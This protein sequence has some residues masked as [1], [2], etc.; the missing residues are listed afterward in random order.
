MDEQKKKAFVDHQS[1]LI[2]LIEEKH[3]KKKQERVD[4]LE[5]GR[6][7]RQKLAEE[8]QKLEVIKDQKIKEMEKLGLNDNVKKQL[9]HVK[10]QI[11]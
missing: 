8:Q 5:E 10:Y 1:A 4:F 6:K 11:I 9:Q 2:Q 7:M 3:D